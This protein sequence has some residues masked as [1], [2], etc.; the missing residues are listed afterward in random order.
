MYY[1]ENNHNKVVL[2]D[3]YLSRFEN[4]AITEPCGT[5]EY[6]G[7][8]FPLNTLVFLSSANMPFQLHHREFGETRPA[9]TIY[10]SLPLYSS[11]I[12]QEILELE[13]KKHF[14]CLFLPLIF[15]FQTFGSTVCCLASLLVSWV[16]AEVSN[17]ALAL[18]GL[19]LSSERSGQL[20][21]T[22][23]KVIRQ[24]N[25]EWE[26]KSPAGTEWEQKQAQQ[27][28]LEHSECSFLNEG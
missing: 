2:R 13:F 18:F 9:G 22:L 15:F 12:P 5:P 10:L 4:G 21:I 28:A 25:K 20:F 23:S 14:Y 17:S 26:Q 19:V 3:F 7:K 1:T 8:M 6:L 11:H 24:I 16:H 27:G